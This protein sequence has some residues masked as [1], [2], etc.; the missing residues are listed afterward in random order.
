VHV[1]NHGLEALSFLET[2]SRW[3]TSVNTKSSDLASLSFILMDLEMPIM[4]G[5]TCTQRIRE[6]ELS[7]Q[8]VGHVPII[9]VTANARAEQMDVALGAGMVGSCGAV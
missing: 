3:I 4:D 5:V 1:A 8:M 7:G 2:T 9:A 6:L